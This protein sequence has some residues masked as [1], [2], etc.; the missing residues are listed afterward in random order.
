MNK[1]LRWGRS[2]SNLSPINCARFA[3][4]LESPIYILNCFWI[5]NPSIHNCRTLIIFNWPSIWFKQLMPKL[6]LSKGV[7]VSGDSFFILPMLSVIL[8][9]CVF[10]AQ[11]S[12]T[13][14]NLDKLKF[15]KMI[16]W[17]KFGCL[18]H[19]SFVALRYSCKCVGGYADQS[20]V[21]CYPDSSYFGLEDPPKKL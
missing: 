14:T 15:V 6:W 18:H 21:H 13:V 3:S 16:F 7:F 4:N 10:H 19:S 5:V 1:Y 20:S 8:F 17:P 9:F 11:L 2:Y 12:F